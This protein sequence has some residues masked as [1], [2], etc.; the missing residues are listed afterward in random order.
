MKKMVFTVKETAEILK[1][2]RG[3][4]YDAVRRGE[5]SAIHIGRRLLVPRLSLETLLGQSIDDNL[6]E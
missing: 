5:I 2:G 3:T 1:I 6:F 4:C